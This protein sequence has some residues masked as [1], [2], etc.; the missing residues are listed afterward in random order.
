M[1][2]LNAL[3]IVIRISS[4]VFRAAYPLGRVILIT[5]PLEMHG[6]FSMTE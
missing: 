3:S 2:V 4:P 6:K 5:R 1:G